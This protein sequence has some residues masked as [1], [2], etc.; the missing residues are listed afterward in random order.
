MGR[1]FVVGRIN[2]ENKAE[3]GIHIGGAGA[4]NWY[5]FVIEC[6]PKAFL[7][8]TLPSE[9]DDFP[10]LVPEECMRIPSFS[11]ALALFSAGRPLRFMR[12]DECV[13]VNRLV[14]FD[15][16]SIGP[17][18]LVPGLWPGIGD[19]CQHDKVLRAFITEF[20]SKLLS[21]SPGLDDG[22]RIFLRRPG[23]R[24]K[25]NQEEL[26]EIAANY[27]YEPI[28]PESFSLKEQV[29]AFA[30]ASSVI[31]PSGAAWVGMIFSERP[32]RGLSWLPRPY[33]H[34]CSYST[35]ASLLGH[36]I[37]F[38]EARTQRALKST[39]DA[40]TAE[41]RICPIEFENALQ[42]ITRVIQ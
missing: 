27:G 39:G 11:D 6:L 16:V 4:F 1:Y 28:S 38:L 41:Y 40:Y 30:N 17:F 3:S 14:V 32:L 8:Q 36:R 31:G 7:A 5:H 24:R 12:R 26:I 21:L 23:V 13:L 22:R 42:Q 35:L 10:L 34:F 19:Y 20:R 29:T 25:Y 18:N 9:F 33:R 37:D 15:E 2:A